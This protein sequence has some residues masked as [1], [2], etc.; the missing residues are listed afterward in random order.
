MSPDVTIATRMTTL[1]IFTGQI[2][3]IME[4]IQTLLTHILPTINVEP[5][6]PYCFYFY[7]GLMLPEGG[8]VPAEHTGA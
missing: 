5:G 8:A 4:S 3:S 1:L 6:K 7:R 2:Y